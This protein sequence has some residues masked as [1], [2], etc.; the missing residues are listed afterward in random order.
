MNYENGLWRIYLDCF[1]GSVVV[2]NECYLSGRMNSM[3]EA[4]DY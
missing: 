1:K 2:N 4:M 3:C